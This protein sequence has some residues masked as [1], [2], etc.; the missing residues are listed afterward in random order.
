MN[1]YIHTFKDNEIF[2]SM[3]WNGNCYNNSVM[4]N[5]FHTC[6]QCEFCLT[7]NDNYCPEIKYCRGINLDGG[8]AD[9]TVVSDENTVNEIMKITNGRGVDAV[10]D[11]VGIDATFNMAKAITKS[12]GTIVINGINEDSLGVAYGKIKGGVDVRVSEGG[13][14][15]Q[16]RQLVA[17]AQSDKLKINVEHYGFDQLPKALDDLR[18]GRITGRGVINLIKSGLRFNNIKLLSLIHI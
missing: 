3:S 12:L 5:F 14:L 18:N 13:T 2:Q 7:G 11:F 9:Y 6:G 8:L 16:M 17:L 1:A 10:I 4:E 15:N